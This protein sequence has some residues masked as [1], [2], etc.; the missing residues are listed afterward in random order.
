MPE[1]ADC[2]ICAMVAATPPDRWVYE[3]ESW[4][5]GTL[6]GLEIPGWIVLA[7]R[8]HAVGAA[9]L[10]ERECRDLGAALSPPL[11]ALAGATDAERIYLQAYGEQEAHWH[12]L[13]SARGPEVPPEHRH[14]QFFLHRQ[15]TSTL[16]RHSGPRIRSVQQCGKSPK[17]C[18]ATSPDPNA[19]GG[20]RF[21]SDLPEPPPADDKAMIEAPRSGSAVAISG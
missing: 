15:D 18:A 16:L 3:N 12:L 8:R 7:L 19:P 21:A 4:V 2:A 10:A 11:G 13:L 14:V 17:P 5:A 1:I 9:P 6:P 20:I